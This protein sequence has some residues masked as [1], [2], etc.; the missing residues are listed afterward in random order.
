MNYDK[1]DFVY[2]SVVLF[3]KILYTSKENI[4]LNSSF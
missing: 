1:N 4:D 2:L 3:N